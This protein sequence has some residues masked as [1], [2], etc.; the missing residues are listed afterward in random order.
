MARVPTEADRATGDEVE[1]LDLVLLLLD[2][3][4]TLTWPRWD[5]QI[6]GFRKLGPP[7]RCAAC[8]MSPAS[9]SRTA[10]PVLRPASS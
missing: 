6:G 8:L 7:L 2:G 3:V 9:Q 4:T 5:G 1:S 10:F